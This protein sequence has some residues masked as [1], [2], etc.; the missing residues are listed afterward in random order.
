M[1]DNKKPTESTTKSVPAVTDGPAP[2]QRPQTTSEP[3]RTTVAQKEP[4]HVKE[5][6][7]DKNAGAK[8]DEKKEQKDSSAESKRLQGLA[9]AEEKIQKL[10]DQTKEALDEI[11]GDG[12][13]A[14]AN[15]LQDFSARLRRAK[16]VGAA[17]LRHT[18]GGSPEEKLDAPNNPNSER[19][20][21]QGSF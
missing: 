10:V 21:R 6:T 12:Q 17:P 4:E 15:L 18:S 7:G 20:K 5:N 11:A 1:S 3:G 2:G 8:L 16:N 9:D 19:V 14:D 13:V